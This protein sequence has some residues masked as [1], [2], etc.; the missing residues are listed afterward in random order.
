VLAAFDAGLHRPTIFGPPLA[1]GATDVL[2]D[3]LADAG[4]SVFRG[5][6]AW[7]LGTDDADML[8]TLARMV[9]DSDSVVASVPPAVR[10]AWYGDRCRASG[11]LVGHVDLLA[12]P[13]T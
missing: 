5:D 7:H 6:S 10:R 9:V 2:A 3:L 4:Y 1:G 11:G 13:P 8:E 12:L